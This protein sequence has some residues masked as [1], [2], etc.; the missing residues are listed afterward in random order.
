MLTYLV[1]FLIFLV[2]WTVVGGIL[3]RF[4]KSSLATRRGLVVVFPFL[5]VLCVLCADGKGDRSDS[6]L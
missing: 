3:F 4:G 1:Y 5:C 2:V 6:Y